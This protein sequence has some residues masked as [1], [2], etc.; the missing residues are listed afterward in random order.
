MRFLQELLGLGEPTTSRYGDIADMLER[1]ALSGQIQR[2][3]GPIP[4]YEFLPTGLRHSM[5]FHVTSSLVS[6]LAPLILFLRSALDYHVLVI[7]EPEAHLHL[8][9][10]RL[11][12]KAL[13]RLV[14][15]GLCVWFTTHSDTLLEQ[16]NHLLK[17]S[18]L[19][20]DIRANFQTQF[21]YADEDVLSPDAVAGYQFTA[22][23]SGKT[24]I[25]PLSQDSNGFIVPT[26]SRA[27]MDL[28][29]EATSLHEEGD[30]Q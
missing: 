1:E 11:L 19:P 22:G 17:M 25:A 24:V 18:S 27:L 29:T 23:A 15:R 28:L 6:E 4:A 21:H 20:P 3:G 26:F 16:M 14:N 8:D 10:Q 5:P 30:I 9:V 7:E 13:V 12:V 2:H